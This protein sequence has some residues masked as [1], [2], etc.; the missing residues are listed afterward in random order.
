MKKKLPALLCVALWICSFSA[1]CKSTEETYRIGKR[2]PVDENE[3]TYTLSADD[4]ETYY[5]FIELYDGDGDVYDIGDPF[6]FRF[7]GKYYLYTSLNGEKKYTGKIPCWV[8]DNLVD[9]QWAGWAYGGGK[10]ENPETYIAFAPEVVYYR[11]WF[12]MCESQRG[13]GHYFFRSK[14][15]N[16][17]FEQITENL[18]QNIDGSFYLADDGELY[19][20][21]ATLNG[22]AYMKV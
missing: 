7:D 19:F 2:N 18:G 21:S 13:Y 1:G 5:N 8:S 15:P 16:G 11:G 3:Q 9:W 10:S 14:N 12:Y 17:P 6:V 22:I 20:M 4:Y